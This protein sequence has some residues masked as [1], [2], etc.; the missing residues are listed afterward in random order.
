MLLMV[1]I[2]IWSVRVRVPMKARL[3]DMRHEGG[4]QL[5]ECGSGGRRVMGNVQSSRRDCSIFTSI[6]GY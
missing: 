1:Y 2:W 4:A 6:C 5:A 3:D